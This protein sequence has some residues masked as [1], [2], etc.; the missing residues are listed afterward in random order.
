MLLRHGAQRLLHGAD[1]VDEVGV[2][3]GE[4]G[5]F[6]A[7]VAHLEVDVVVVVARPGG[8]D[9]LVPDAL[10]IEREVARTRSRDEHV[11]AILVDGRFELRIHGIFAIGVETGVRREGGRLGIRAAKID[12]ETLEERSMVGDVRLAHGLH[13]LAFERGEGALVAGVRSLALPLGSGVH[14]V[15]RGESDVE[16]KRVGLLNVKV[17]NAFGVE[18]GIHAILGS[19]VRDGEGAGI[20][21]D[22][23]LAAGSDGADAPL[24][25]L[26][27]GE[28]SAHD[29]RV[30]A[31]DAVGDVVAGSE[32]DLGA[33][34]GGLAGASA[35][36]QDIVR[37][38][39]EALAVVLHAADGKTRAGDGRGEIERADVILDGALGQVEINVNV[40][41]GLVA[42]E[43]VLARLGAV[44]VVLAVVREIGTA[45]P[46]ADLV[47]IDALAVIAAEKGAS[48][49]SVADGERLALPWAS[50]TLAGKIAGVR[51]AR[52]PRD[53]GALDDAGLLVPEE[54]GTLGSVAGGHG[55]QK[56]RGRQEDG[57]EAGK[58]PCGHVGETK[59]VVKTVEKEVVQPMISTRRVTSPKVRVEP[60]ARGTWRS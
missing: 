17:G 11:A 23:E 9:V 59:M 14:L 6:R 29:D 41:E 30:L 57:Q 44:L 36:D 26:A 38:G 43:L 46:K 24:E 40:A 55:G 8:V 53:A 45:S 31:R 56:A 3:L 13:S 27:V 49:A 58:N 21:A 47:E 42:A 5:D 32:T 35:V 4:V 22:A 20:A 28:S 10:E 19:L 7:P 1:E 18:R 16:N 2:A 37:V 33:E 25:S 60:S 54:I 15:I 12:A 50:R 51:L 52:R 48:D 39:D 34:A